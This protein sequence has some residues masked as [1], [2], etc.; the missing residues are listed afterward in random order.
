M[1]YGK[2]LLTHALKFSWSVNCYKVML[3]TCRR[4]PATLQFYESSGFDRHGKQAFV[5]K[6]T[7]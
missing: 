1:G 5:A 6:P 7:I 3:L 4:D 2:A